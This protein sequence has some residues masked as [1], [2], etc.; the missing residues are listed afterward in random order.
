MELYQIIL[1]VLAAI[2][3][4]LYIYRRVTGVDVLKNILLT[5]PVLVALGG[6]TQALYHIWPQK[7][8]L[9]IVN[10]V[11]QASIEAAEVAEKAWKIGNLNKE[12]RNTFAKNLVKDTLRRAGIEITDQVSAVIDG[13][14]EAACIVFPHEPKP[15]P[16]VVGDIG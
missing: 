12:D 14:I 1:L 4:G 5:K 2:V 15:E 10:I 6:V 8:E 3:A 7:K 11:T 13:A 16:E 9:R